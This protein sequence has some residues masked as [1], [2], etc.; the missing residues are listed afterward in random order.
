MSWLALALGLA[1][2]LR[3]WPTLYDHSIFWPDEIHQSLEQAHRAAFGYGLVSWEFRD[4]ARSWLFPGVIAG[5]WNLASAIGVESSLALVLIARL[6]MVA[7]SMVAIWFAA[8]LATV[9]GGMRAALA[10]VVILATF[11]PSVVYAHRAMS[12]TA[13]APFIAMAAWLLWQRNERSAAYAGAAIAIGSL[14][15]YQNGLFAIVFAI[16]LLPQRRYREALAFCSMG[17]A[18]ALFGG[19]LDGITWGHLFHS[20]TTYVEF[21]LMTGGASSFGVEPFWFYATTLWS[22]VG[23]L[24][25]PLVVLFCVGAW[26][27]PILAG[28]VAIYVLAHSV[29]PHKELRFLVPS[30]PLFAAV[31]AIGLDRALRRLPTTRLIPAGAALATSA[32]SCFWLTRLDYQDMGQYAGTKRAASS[33]W[34]NEQEP[35]L[36]LAEA[37]QRADLCGIAV[38]RARAAFTGG[39]TYLHRDVP[40]MYQSE[41]CDVGA[42]NYVIR[43]TQSGGEALPVSYRLE[44]ESGSWGLY[45]RD[46]ICRTP[47][48]EDDRLLEGARDMGLGLRQA[49]QAT[50]GSLRFDLQRDAGAF[51]HNWGHGELLDCDM[52]RWATGTRAA[53]EFDF[54]PGE[55]A[56]QL[57]VRARSHHDIWPQ[58]V[59][60]ATNGMLQRVGGLS[61]ELKTFS[62]DLPDQA[63]RRGRNRIEFVFRR[64]AKGDPSDNRRLTALFRSIE[65]HPKFDDF[66]VDVAL[67]ESRP[68][69][70]RGFHSTE[71]EGGMTYAWSQGPSS[72]VEGRLAKP[73]SP[74]ILQT[75]AEAVPLVP[76]QR[77]R[78]FANDHLVGVLDFPTKWKVQRLVIPAAALRAGKNAIRFEYE[79]AVKPAAL[80]RTQRDERELAVRFRQI[81]LTPVVANARLDLG[82][83]G[84]RPF[85]LEGWSADEREGDRTAVW[86]DGPRSSV[87]LSLSGMARPI[88]R[89]STL[90]YQHALPIA[91]KV[92]LNGRAVGA[93]AAPDG[94]QDIA[95]PLP[96]GDYSPDGELIELTFDHTLRPS[97]HNPQSPDSR[98]LALRVDRIWVEADSRDMI[99]ASV[100]TGDEQASGLPSGVA[101][102]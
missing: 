91:V 31:A 32:L 52:A 4:G 27:E 38:L 40:L 86:T 99:N 88:L 73:R 10:T 98:Q 95:V 51:V 84:A 12:E 70:V 8:R 66:A 48:Q 46:G 62:V 89:L 75:L 44:K 57:T 2:A 22:S 9:R 78:V 39:Y 49:K 79:A 43:S 36:L 58:T 90:G 71:Q 64:S 6:T 69:L 63:L 72:V 14:L 93:F 34:G 100:Q 68:H 18:V 23:P 7:A 20:L 56:Y 85:L 60:V 25:I 26:V 47:L 11:P 13:S 30:F 19:V 80:D 77:T 45:R 76:S 96:P 54:D 59:S 16:V 102:H 1:T 5:I 87:L 17:L 29:L 24:L 74:Y 82:T 33:I 3:I 61:P 35:S 65:I 94:W 28:S 37:G 42:V 21:N 83:A 55:R 81:Q 15:R 50:D 92:S 101:S 67:A 97:E 41:L 53:I